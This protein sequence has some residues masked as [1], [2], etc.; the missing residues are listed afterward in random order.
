VTY[1]EMKKLS[2]KCSKMPQIE[3]AL[4]K[5]SMDDTPGHPSAGGSAPRGEESPDHQGGQGWKETGKMGVWE[6]A[7]GRPGGWGRRDRR[8]KGLALTGTLPRGPLAC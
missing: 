2:L 6:R 8:V 5:I 1:Q 7:K 4:K 3:F